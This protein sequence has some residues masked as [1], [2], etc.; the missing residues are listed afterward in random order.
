MLLPQAKDAGLQ[1]SNLQC[2][3]PNKAK[4]LL[5]LSD[6]ASSGL[7]NSKSLWLYSTD[8]LELTSGF[9]RRRSPLAALPLRSTSM[10]G[11]FPLQHL[12]GFAVKQ[13]NCFIYT[14]QTH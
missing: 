2:Y 12:S 9:L 10:L 7:A 13:Y 8:L 3:Q 14:I 6:V 5:W 1:G 11:L 4:G